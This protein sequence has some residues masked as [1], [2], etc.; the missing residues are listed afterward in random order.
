[1]TPEVDNVP[2]FVLPGH[3]MPAQW[4]LASLHSVQ[5]QAIHVMVGNGCPSPLAGSCL[6]VR[7]TGCHFTTIDDDVWILASV[8]P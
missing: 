6:Q 3:A 4:T 1:M 7:V 5:L 2:W 8:I